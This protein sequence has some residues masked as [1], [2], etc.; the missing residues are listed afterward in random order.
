MKKGCLIALAAGLALVVIIILLAFGLTR[1]AV[2]AGDE[3]LGLIGSGKVAA[4]YEKASATLKSQQTEESFEQAVKNLGLTDFASASWSS[5][6]TKNDRAHLEGSVKTRAGGKIPLT[7]ELVK[8]SGTWKVIYLS[9]PQ[10]GISVEQGGKQLPSD[11][12]SKALAL[13]S[14]LAFNKAVQDKSFVGF[15]QQISRRWQEQ[16]TPDKLKEVFN[17]FIETHLDISPI[18]EVQPVL[19]AAPEINSD[20]ILVL[21][22]YYPT[23]PTKVYFRL[24]YIYEHPAWKLFGI[25][26]NVNQ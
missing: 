25:Q 23:H 26:V 8:E 10:A 1:G 2:K 5:R 16:I 22:G 17:Q 21:E 3:F 13:D 6:E 19:S 4:A 14:L 11:E 9:G 18:K 24:K 15:H 20:G 7:M 12:K